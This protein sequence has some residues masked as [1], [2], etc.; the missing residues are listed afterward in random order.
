MHCDVYS[1][2]SWSVNIVGRKKWIMFPP[3]EENKL[4]DKFGNLPPLFDS[5]T[6]PNVKYFEVIQDKGDA[7]FVPSGWHHQ[8]ENTL[9][10]ISIN[11]NFINGSN[12]EFVWEAFKNNLS[13][14]ENE[15]KE[16]S[17]TP[18]FV[19]QCQRMLKVVFGMDYTAIIKFITYIGEKRVKQCHGAKLYSFN[20]FVLGIN[21]LKFDLHILIKILYQI[22]QH[23][24]YQSDYL[25]PDEK[26][27]VEDM[28]NNIKVLLN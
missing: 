13:S 20:K 3:G 18:C 26:N 16:F 4:K 15:I 1:S 7:I 5:K 28:I 25:I 12:L 9:D 10:T 27:N 21:H 11:H 8:V 23:P 24:L 2:Y 6:Y 19:S 17:N 22:Q 14:V